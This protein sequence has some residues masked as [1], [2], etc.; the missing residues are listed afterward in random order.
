ML[1][2]ENDSRGT[3]VAVPDNRSTVARGGV[4][5]DGVLDG[6]GTTGACCVGIWVDVAVEV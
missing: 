4:S 3:V 5:G 6:V 2:G 1:G